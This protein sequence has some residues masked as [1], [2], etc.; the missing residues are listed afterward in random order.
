[1]Y[2]AINNKILRD[3]RFNMY[4]RLLT[5]FFEFYEAMIGKIWTSSELDEA[6]NKMLM[7][8]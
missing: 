1:M 6:K 3:S 5:L 2:E 4:C 7:A 8:H